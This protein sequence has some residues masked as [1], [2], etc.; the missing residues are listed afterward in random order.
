MYQYQDE[1]YIWSCWYCQYRIPLSPHNMGPI[2]RYLFLCR[3]SRTLF[4]GIKGQNKNDDYDNFILA[5]TR[6]CIASEYASNHW[7]RN[8]QWS[9]G[10]PKVWLSKEVNLSARIDRRWKDQG[11][12]QGGGLAAENLSH[13]HIYDLHHPQRRER[14][15]E[16]ERAQAGD[17]L[18][19]ASMR[20][21]L[22][23]HKMVI[24]SRANQTLT[25]WHDNN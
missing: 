18:L 13:V 11:S 6:L 22:E 17:V 20:N 21:L 14:E 8:M 10:T 3:M 9:C 7:G 24:L 16:S 12:T 1:N 23:P 2:F 4:S 15:G 25:F 5:D 19:K